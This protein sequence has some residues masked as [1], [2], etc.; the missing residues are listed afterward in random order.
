MTYPD[1]IPAGELP[2]TPH[3]TPGYAVAAVL[4]MTTGT[5]YT[6]VGIKTRWVHSFLSAAYLSSLG[7]TILILYVMA[8]P[9]STGIQGAYV[10]AIASTGLILGVVAVLF[11]EATECLGCLLGGFCFSMWILTLREGGLIPQTGGKVVFIAALTL[12][13]FGTYFSRWTRHYSLIACV[14]FSG[15]TAVVLGIDCFSR[16]GLKEFWTYIWA[17]NDHLF[18]LGAGTYPHTKGIK[19]ELAATVLIFLAGMISQLRLWRVIRDRR[20]G[21]EEVRRKGR[22]A[23]EREEQ[24]IGRQVEVLN[25]RERRRWERVYGMGRGVDGGSE[26]SGV[27]DM[28][29]RSEMKMRESATV[30]T[31]V[32]RGEVETPG[33]GE[34]RMVEIPLDDGVTTPEPGVLSQDP[35]DGMV[36]VRVAQDEAG[37]EPQ[38]KRIWVVGTD[39]EARYVSET[40]GSSRTFSPPPEV[41]PLPFKIPTAEEEEMGED[42]SSVAAYVDEDG[43]VRSMMESRRDSFAKRLSVG[44]A[45]M[46]RSLSQ[47]SKGNTIESYEV[48]GESREELVES[49]QPRRY[50]DADSLAAN[51]DDLSSDDGRDDSDDERSERVIDMQVTPKRQNELEKRRSEERSTQ[52]WL[53]PTKSRTGALRDSAAETISTLPLSF[54]EAEGAVPL[55]PTDKLNAGKVS[56]EEDGGSANGSEA[57]LRK[58]KSYVSAE[59]L[60][61]AVLKPEHLPRPLS[62]VALSYRTNEWAKHLSHAEAPE[63]EDLRLN[64]YFADSA[65]AAVEEPAPLDV[66]E[67]QKTADNAAR[68]AAAPRSA[69][70]MS[71]SLTPHLSMSRNNSRASLLQTETRNISPTGQNLPP[72]TH[73]NPKFRSTSTQLLTQPIA[74]EGDVEHST[75]PSPRISS[76]D[77]KDTSD[78]QSS[79]SS[80]LI[81]D[82][83]F[84]SAS[85]SNPNLLSRPPVPGVVSYSSPQTLMGRR[86]TLLRN[87][88]QLSFY[89]A[90]PEPGLSN[91]RDL[92]TIHSRSSSEAGSLYNYPSVGLGLG[93]SRNSLENP[94]DL[95]DLPLSQRREILRQSSLNILAPTSTPSPDIQTRWSSTNPVLPPAVRQA[96]LASFRSSVQADLRNGAGF[97]S[98]YGSNANLSNVA[99]GGRDADIRRSVDQQRSYLMNQKEAEARMKELERIGRWRDEREFEERMRRGE[100][101]GA[102]REAMRRLQ[103]GVR[104]L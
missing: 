69:S 77:N 26:D 99:I 104:D 57:T 60:Q 22:R 56:L 1:T 75:S 19:V 64:Q 95:D 27:G 71:N 6:L 4:L 102:H 51:M 25:H 89:G 40:G 18:P 43:E 44:S 72:Q 2:L 67:L 38:E 76:E 10:A 66:E 8:L 3:V 84:P 78:P 5:V 29:S 41:I 86:E 90:T 103:G 58:A 63:P 36:T 96:Q 65:Q 88:S 82:P 92:S 15:A 49:R 30:V 20:A 93:S 32:E 14:S 39:G 9:V 50:D 42:R 59:Q 74:E 61:P 85:A 97:T 83:G 62:R 28:G 46:M 79:R 55:S 94:A 31:A 98:P 54:I 11:K 45:K 70:A 7:T 53:S 34:Y 80:P 13:C 21:R 17:L 37:L 100:L 48:G 24:S 101:L 12:G 91:L 35:R 73:K 81:P 68:P 16:A 23:V 47:R 87:K 33:P 52:G